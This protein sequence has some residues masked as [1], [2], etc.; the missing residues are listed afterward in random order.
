MKV[1]R[2]QQPFCA[3]TDGAVGLLPGI[4]SGSPQ[5]CNLDSRLCGRHT[6]QD[7]SPLGPQTAV[8]WDFPML[9]KSGCG[10]W[11]RTSARCSSRGVDAGSGLP[12][13]VQVGVW[14][15]AQDFFPMLFKSGCG[16]RLRTSPRCSSRGVDAGSGL[17]HAAQVGVW[18]PAQS[19][20]VC[21]ITSLLLLFSY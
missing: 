3:Q 21:T 2:H 17:P 19:G 15:L 13:A 1:K 11:L 6:A 7:P 5:S 20:G 14:K 8:T 10:S 16:C 12:H 9:F 18:M 4:V